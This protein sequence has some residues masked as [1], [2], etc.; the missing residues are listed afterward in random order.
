MGDAF[1]TVETRASGT[2]TPG[3]LFTTEN[4]MLSASY[5]IAAGLAVFTTEN[6]TLSTSRG[7]AVSVPVFTT[8]NT[9][10]SAS[11]GC[12]VGAPV[13]ATEKVS[14]STSCGCADKVAVFTTENGVLSTSPDSLQF[15]GVQLGSSGSEPEAISTA[16]EKPSPSVSALGSRI[17]KV[18]FLPE[19]ELELPDPFVATSVKAPSAPGAIVKFRTADVPLGSVETEFTVMTDAGVKANVEPV[20]LNPVTLKNCTF[21]AVAELSVNLGVTAK[22]TGAGELGNTVNALVRETISVPVVTVTE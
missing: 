8:E 20:K 13:F 19:T 17:L 5:A 22:I 15:S 4:K 14:L 21:V 2:V 3:A 12:G 16:L 10:L 6:V 7:C 1:E 9:I 18:L 11:R